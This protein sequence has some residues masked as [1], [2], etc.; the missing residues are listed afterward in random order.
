MKRA[1]RYAALVFVFML[2]F[3]TKKFIFALIPQ[4]YEYVR[5]FSS[6][7]LYA[8]DI[9][10]LIL[11]ALAFMYA[12][13]RVLR[14]PLVKWYGVLGALA[15]ASLFFA[16]NFAYSL[17]VAM[18][19]ILALLVSLAVIAAMQ[20]GAVN[21][22][23]IF[24]ALA[25]SATLQAV[26]A[27]AQ[28]YYQKSVGLWILGESVITATTPGVARVDIGGVSFL[29]A[30][31]TLPHANILAGFLVM[32]LIACAYL[33][34]TAPRRHPIM[35]AGSAMAFFAILSALV[36][37]FSRSGWIVASFAIFTIGVYATWNKELRASAK[38]FIAVTLISLVALSLVLGSAVVS[39]AGFA[40]GEFSV[41]HRIY[42]NEMGLTLIAQHP[43]GVGIGNE[44]LQA[45]REG[46][47]A[48]KGL[49]QVWLWQPVHNIY[50][51]I[52]SELGIAG[53][54]VFF[55]MAFVVFRRINFT[56]PDAVFAGLLVTSLL[57]FGFV[58]HFPWDLHAG[59]LMFWV[60]FGIMGAVTLKPSSSNG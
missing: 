38:E 8:T 9:L 44:V 41:D 46:L 39:R 30:Y 40:K 15:C 54:A 16:L 6:F 21:I 4:M 35:H 33:Y 55:L 51:L 20:E 10:A 24:K 12:G 53:L 29:R 14:T 58:D 31:G 34:L 37:T 18:G 27:I 23:D 52:A 5:E 2:P 25:A 36:F 59:R 57:L 48:A 17:Y 42:Y 43:L 19:F 1:L 45:A 22:R 7:L 11:V 28:F 60:A 50:I 49:T 47:F 3:G 13:R 56:S 26:I 32:G